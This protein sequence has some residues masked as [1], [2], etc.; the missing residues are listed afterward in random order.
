MRGCFC[1]R[2]GCR[3]MPVPYVFDNPLF[4]FPLWRPTACKNTKNPKNAT[5]KQIKAT[6]KQIKATRKQINK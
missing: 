3:A 6:G 5:G 2:Q 1:Y 4:F